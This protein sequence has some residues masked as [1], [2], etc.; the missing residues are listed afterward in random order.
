MRRRREYLRLRRELLVSLAEAQRT[1]LRY[2][3]ARLSGP[4]RLIDAVLAV[5]RAFNFYRTV[6]LTGA[7]MLSRRRKGALFWIGSA[8][9]LWRA[10]RGRGKR[11]G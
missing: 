3:T 2:V 9:A 11:G 4:L 8:L 5:N 1:E 10:L 7:A 6:A